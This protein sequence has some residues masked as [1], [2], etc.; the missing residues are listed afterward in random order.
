MIKQSD[1]QIQAARQSFNKTVKEEGHFMGANIIEI[2]LNDHNQQVL[3]TIFVKGREQLLFDETKKFI[4]TFHYL[5]LAQWPDRF[6]LND[7]FNGPEINEN[8][9]EIQ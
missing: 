6:R 8:V 9:N 3:Q 4:S 5:P 1:A 2:L 7:L